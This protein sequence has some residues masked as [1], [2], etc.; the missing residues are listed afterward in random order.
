MAHEQVTQFYKILRHKP[1]MWSELAEI[2]DEDTVIRR[3]ATL[4]A[5]HDITLSPEDIRAALPDLPDIIAE[6]AEDG[7]LSDDELELVAAGIHS[8]CSLQNV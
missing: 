1:D 7:E 6:A 4:S 8:P 2:R 3:I 5:A